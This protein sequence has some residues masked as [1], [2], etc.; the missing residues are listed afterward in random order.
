MRKVPKT[1]EKEKHKEEDKEAGAWLTE[2]EWE[3]QGTLTDS[4]ENFYFM[5]KVPKTQEKER[6]KEENKEDKAS[7]QNNNFVDSEENKKYIT[8]RCNKNDLRNIKL[9]TDLDTYKKKAG[10][11]FKKIEVA[12]M[13]KKDIRDF[14]R[15]KKTIQP[16]RKGIR[17]FFAE[18]LKANLIPIEEEYY[19]EPDSEG[20]FSKN[21]DVKEYY[22]LRHIVMLRLNQKKRIDRNEH[23]IRWI[24]GRKKFLKTNSKK[25]IKG[26]P[27]NYYKVPK[28]LKKKRKLSYNSD[29]KLPLWSFVTEYIL[30]R[31]KTRFTSRFLLQTFKMPNFEGHEGYAM[32]DYNKDLRLNQFTASSSEELKKFPSFLPFS[33]DHFPYSFS[34]SKNKKRRFFRFVRHKEHKG[35]EEHKGH[36][37]K[38]KNREKQEMRV[39]NRRFFKDSTLWQKMKMRKYRKDFK[40]KKKKK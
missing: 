6:H 10:N 23:K 34:F 27:F 35:G 17:G 15:V 24:K 3:V 16:T 11:E 25:T 2:K 30:L 39:V 37:S 18:Y 20:F 19:F 28:R 7:V 12:L 31:T 5:R 26:L 21:P 4:E 8:N 9:L 13:T 14:K 29:S 33:F 22:A 1:Q 40:K 38:K 36:L 32:E